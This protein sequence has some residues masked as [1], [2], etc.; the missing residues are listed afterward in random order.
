MRK[1]DRINLPAVNSCTSFALCVSIWN[2]LNSA[3]SLPFGP[4]SFSITW[5]ASASSRFRLARL[6]SRQPIRPASTRVSVTAPTLMKNAVR[7]VLMSGSRSGFRKFGC[8]AGMVAAAGFFS[9]GFFGGGGMAGVMGHQSEET[10]AARAGLPGRRAPFL[11]KV[12]WRD[13]SQAFKSGF[14]HRHS[15]LLGDRLSSSQ[16]RFGGSWGQIIWP[17]DWPVCT[18]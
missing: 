16:P 8:Q 18:S 5:L 13:W 9:R 7:T 10:Q 6:S 2:L 3:T 14:Q 12:I 1:S 4:L 15:Q 11:A 17:I